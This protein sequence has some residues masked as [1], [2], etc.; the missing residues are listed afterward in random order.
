MPPVTKRSPASAPFELDD[1]ASAATA[2]IGELEVAEALYVRSLG[3][4]FTEVPDGIIVRHDGLP[5]PVFN[6][7]AHL[8]SSARKFGAFVE[9]LEDDFEVTGLPWGI[10]TSPGSMPPDAAHKLALRGYRNTGGRI[11]MELEESP[12]ARPDDG[13]VE[14]RPTQD[15]ELWA[16]TV[17]EGVGLVGYTHFLRELARLSREAPDHR[18]LL[19]TYGGTPAGACELTRDTNV[20]F[21]RH[22]GVRPDFRRRGIAQAMLSS[23]FRLATE[24]KSVRLAT[25]VIAGSGADALFEKYG[26]VASH[27]SELFTRRPVP[28]TMD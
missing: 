20:A 21:V 10:M 16:E 1:F 7:A 3:G 23:A 13:R 17:A 19:A 25:R 12:P 22:L 18:L 15:T 9:R 4:S 14:V 27:A 24:L 26:F 8:T 2:A 11:W 6:G 5:H 28:F